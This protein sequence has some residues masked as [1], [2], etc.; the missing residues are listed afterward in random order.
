MPCTLDTPKYPKLGGWVAR[1]RKAYR[2]EK[3]RENGE[4]VPGPHKVSQVRI[5]RLEAAGFEWTDLK[6]AAWEDKVA[7]LREYIQVCVYVCCSARRCGAGCA[8]EALAHVWM[9]GWVGPVNQMMECVR[10]T[11]IG[12]QSGTT[13]NRNERALLCAAPNPNRNS[14]T[15]EFPQ[16]STLQSI[17]SWAAG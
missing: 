5:A 17:P 1:Q 2:C 8:A 9:G 12:C 7:L 14:A 11:A 16:H 10:W 13:H 3:R 4:I 15:R 6:R